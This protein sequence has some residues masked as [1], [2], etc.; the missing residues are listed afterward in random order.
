MKTILKMAV[1]LASCATLFFVSSA[2]AGTVHSFK[3][4]WVNWP[5]YGSRL[6]DENGT[7]KIQNIDVTIGDNGWLQKIDIVLHDSTHRQKFDSL[8]I[9]TSWDGDNS[10]W[11]DWTH[12][13]HDGGSAR[14]NINNTSG[15]IPLDGLYKVDTNF[16]YTT[17]INANRITNP[18]GIDNKFLDLLDSSFG[19]LHNDYHIVYDFGAG[20]SIGDGFFVAY[21]PWC[22]NDV[23]GGGYYMGPTG[24]PVP[25]PATM[26]LFSAGLLGFAGSRF[27]SRKSRDVK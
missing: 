20:L 23:A 6:G 10:T 1:L 14:Y 7:P 19:G 27:R 26:L 16:E 5:G 21:A 15:N 9:N 12:F 24:D 18:N 11:D 22:A 4:T 2:S 3:D 25:E 8:F 17:V 13:V